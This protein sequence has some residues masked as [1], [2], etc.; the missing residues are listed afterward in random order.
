MFAQP[1][2]AGLGDISKLDPATRDAMIATSRRDYAILKLQNEVRAERVG[3]SYVIAIGY[4]AT[5]P[6]LATRSPKPMPMPISPI[7]SMP[8]STPPSGRR[9]G[10]RAG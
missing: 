8:A 2:R 1:R 10:C 7:S 3:R 6:A 9:S 4:Q 5:D